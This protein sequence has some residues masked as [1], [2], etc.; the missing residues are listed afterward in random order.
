MAVAVRGGHVPGVILHTDQGSEYTA[1]LFRAACKRL[2]VSQS[3][4][5]PGSALDNAVIESWHPAVEF[6]LRRIEHFATRAAARA[7]VAALDRGVQHRPPA[8]GLR[9]DVPGGLG[10]G[11]QAEGR[12]SAAGRCAARDEKKAASP[13]ISG[14]LPRSRRGDAPLEGTGP[15][16]RPQGIR[17]G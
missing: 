4:G 8:L 17:C 6:E 11:R 3:M 14:W 9:H 1:R 16:L 15:P 2:S 5:R 7:R 13:F 12:V 10:A